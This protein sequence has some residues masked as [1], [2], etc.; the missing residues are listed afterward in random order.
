M[1]PMNDAIN[2]MTKP[3]YNPKDLI[4]T[5]PAMDRISSEGIGEINDCRIIAKINPNGPN[6]IIMS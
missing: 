5:A 6:C 1:D 2:A 3:S 4:Y